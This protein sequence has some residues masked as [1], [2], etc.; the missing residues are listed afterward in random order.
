MRIL[1]YINYAV[2]IGQTA[3]PLHCLVH[4]I[5]QFAAGLYGRQRH[6]GIKRPV[7]ISGNTGR[8]KKSA[9]G[10]DVCKT[11][12]GRMVLYRKTEGRVGKITHP[13]AVRPYMRLGIYAH[14]FILGYAL[15]DGV[16]E[17]ARRRQIVA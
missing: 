4:T 1:L 17:I 6:V 16:V 5:A 15:V 13:R 11:I 2:V 3:A 10:V 12:C 7:D 8:L 14:G 9:L